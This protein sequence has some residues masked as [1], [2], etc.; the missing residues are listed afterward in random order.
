VALPVSALASRWLGGASLVSRASRKVEV[1]SSRWSAPMQTAGG[2]GRKMARERGGEEGCR[3]GKER[4]SSAQL[5]SSVSQI[6]LVANVFLFAP[7]THKRCPQVRAHGPAPLNPFRRLDISTVEL[8]MSLTA[9]HRHLRVP[10]CR[11]SSCLRRPS[12]CW[13]SAERSVWH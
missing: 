11:A 13:R 10:L 12:C 5:G 3:E 9:S 7:D 2:M 8:L 6:I 4:A 1:S